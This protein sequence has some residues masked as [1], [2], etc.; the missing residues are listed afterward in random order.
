MYVL[1]YVYMYIGLVH[2]QIHF[3]AFS[4]PPPLLALSLSQP[5]D[6]SLICIYKYGTIENRLLAFI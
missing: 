3:K 5:N 2:F 6:H 4:I 1:M